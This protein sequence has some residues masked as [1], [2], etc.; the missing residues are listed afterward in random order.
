MGAPPAG[1]APTT[2]TLIRS[3]SSTWSGTPPGSIHALG[4][5]SV[6]GV[7]GHDAG[8][9][10]AA[11]CALVRPDVFRKVTLMSSPFA[12]APARG[13]RHRQ[14]RRAA[15]C[16]A[17]RRRTRRGTGEA[18]AAAQVLPEPS[19]HARRQR[20]HAARPAGP[21]RVL[22]RLLPLQ[23]R[24]LEREQAA[25][26]QGADRRRAGEDAD[27]LRDGQ[28]QGHG[29]VGR[30]VHADGGRGRGLPVAHRRRGRRVCH[31]VRQDGIH[32]RAAR[33]SGAAR[34]R[35]EIDGGDA[36]VRRTHHRRAGLLHRGQ[37][38]LGHLSDPRRLRGDADQSLHTMARRPSGRGCRALGA[39]GAAASRQQA[40]HPILRGTP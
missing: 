9:P 22:S 10:V 24:R 19:A 6:A 1:M 39:A 40:P 30:A 15:A 8:S 37:S 7:A 38:R 4:Y 27:L 14:R 5:R 13:A 34:Q 33:L 18:A 28:G 23:E 12:G 17:D 11:W 20:R 31:R 16:G 32:R 26:A 2:P 29:R 36:H 35:S 3:A 21:A 25:S